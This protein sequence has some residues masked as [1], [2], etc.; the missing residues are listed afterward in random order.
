MFQPTRVKPYADPL[1]RIGETRLKVVSRLCYLGSTLSHN[2]LID[3][4]ISGLIHCVF[5]SFGH[6]SHR[7]QKQHGI[8]LESKINLYKVVVP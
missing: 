3:K 8:R 5:V 1:I 2:A 4:K 7:V 6:V